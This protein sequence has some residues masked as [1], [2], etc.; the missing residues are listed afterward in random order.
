M[1]KI[2]I[3]LIAMSS[4]MVIEHSQELAIFSE[5][6]S[7]QILLD[8]EEQNPSHYTNSDYGHLI[9]MKET[10]TE[11]DPSNSSFEKNI[12]PTI[13]ENCVVCHN[14]N[15]AMGEVN[16]DSYQ[17]ILPYVE[18]GALIGSIRHEPDWKIMPPAGEKLNECQIGQIEKWIEE[19]AKEN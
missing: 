13:K 7:Q 5:N 17:A 9:K 12:M 14:S 15:F 3:G 10:S 2:W 4:F 6:P 1:L 8:L 19:G 16:L 18:S 11:C